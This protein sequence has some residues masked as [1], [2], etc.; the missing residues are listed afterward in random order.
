M[1]KMIK[2]LNRVIEIVMAVLIAAMV[3][4]NFWQ[5]FTRFVVGN[6][7]SWTEEF[8]RYALIWLT[9]LGIPYAYGKNKHIALEF[10]AD[11]FSDKGRI[12]DQLFIEILIMILS[13]FV[14][15]CGGIMVTANARGQYSAALNMPMVFYYIGVP[16]CGVLML[17]YTIP[18][19]VDCCK[20]MKSG[21]IADIASELGEDDNKEEGK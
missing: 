2:T 18:R 19:F 6:A 8:M 5:I 21:K 1:K 11:K 9:M 7:A 15:I 12:R 14:M 4:A 16:I 20:A 3:F 13:V 17:I 10:I